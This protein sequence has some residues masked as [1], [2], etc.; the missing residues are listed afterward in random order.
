MK[1]L[2]SKE[3]NLVGEW[4]LLYNRNLVL[5]A[6]RNISDERGRNTCVGLQIFVE[7]YYI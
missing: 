7:K 1:P 6:W 3:K 5:L 2:G 4:V